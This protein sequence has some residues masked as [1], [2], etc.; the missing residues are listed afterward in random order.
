MISCTRDHRSVL[1]YDVRRRPKLR[2]TNVRVYMTE[3]K[4][5]HL[6]TSRAEPEGRVRSSSIRMHKPLHFKEH[7]LH[8][9]NCISYN[10][11]TI[12]EKR[13]LLQNNLLDNRSYNEN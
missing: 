2:T 13:S 7:V 9:N 10:T 5:T 11:F 4:L 12:S 6:P 8:R 1:D 3:F